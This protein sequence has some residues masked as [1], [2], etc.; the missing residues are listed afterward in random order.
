M[1]NTSKSQLLTT[2]ILQSE[3]QDKQSVSSEFFEDGG[4]DGIK[5]WSNVEQ[6]SPESRLNP[7]RDSQPQDSMT[8]QEASVGATSM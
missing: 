2:K 8:P 4:V 6:P 5:P 3:P 1:D 7:R